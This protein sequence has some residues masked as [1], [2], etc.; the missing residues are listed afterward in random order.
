MP[1]DTTASGQRRRTFLKTA[2]GVATAGIAGCS[3]NESNAADGTGETNNS[4]ESAGGSSDEFS[5]DTLSLSIPEAANFDPVQIKGDGSQVVSDHVFSELLTL[6]SDGLEPTAQ[7]VS[8]YSV[9]ED[10]QTY[11]F[12]LREGVTFHNGDEL[13]ADDVVYS[14]ERLAASENS[15]EGETVLEGSFRIAHE[16]MTETVDGEEQEVYQPGSLA[17]EAVDDY[18]LEVTLEQA[19]F[20]ALFW[21]AYGSLSPVPEGIVGDIEGYDGNMEYSEFSSQS[22]VGTGPFQAESVETGTEVVLSAADDYYG[23]EPGPDRI[24]MQV[25]QNS[26]A[27][28]QRA[29]NRSVQVFRLP[30]SRF[31]PGKVSIE[32]TRNLGQ[33]VGTYGPLEN[34]ETVNY[35]TWDEAYTAYFIFDCSRVEKPVRQAL[36]YAVNQEN[37]VEQGFRG[38]GEPAYHQAPPSVYPGG[39]EAYDRHA[40][41]NFPYGYREA[42]VDEA[43]SVMEDAGYGENNR[44]SIT[45]TLYNDRNPDAY[46]R[47]ADLIRSKA[48]AVYVDLSIERA[49][50]NTIIDE[51]VSGN[52]D[53][54][55]LGNGLEY[56][57]PAD[58][59][60]FGRP[61]EGNLVRWREDPSDASERAAAAWEEIQSNLGPTDAEEEAR[62]EAFIQ[63]EEAIWEDAIYLTNYHPR[64]RQWWYDSVDA[65]IQP[66]GFHDRL[67][68]DVTFE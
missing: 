3:G 66:S 1:E 6:P 56:P 40:E 35:S 7:L 12:T 20:D 68:N 17:V 54:Y 8:D 59:L 16:T 55:T 11:T 13:T 52:L 18:T 64:G 62:S 67:Y 32:E 63:M 2:G 15:Q 46:S 5:G 49:P 19:F 43:R 31:D 51:A 48:Q 45:L 50:F 10:G 34:G 58:M 27:I 39:K 26:D 24:A 36:N 38:V 9:S 65:P 53:M 44:A 60:K 42:Q 14:W 28:H 21:F 41:E 57:S 37:F 29:M 61:Y 23:D 4:N 47:I 25:V 22:P 30:N 33:E